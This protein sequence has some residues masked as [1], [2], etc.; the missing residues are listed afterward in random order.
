MNFEKEGVSPA[1]V[2]LGEDLEGAFFTLLDMME[3]KY[4]KQQKY[5]QKRM[6][7]LET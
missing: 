4:V 7:Q 6:L 5:D 1:E 2:L 3:E